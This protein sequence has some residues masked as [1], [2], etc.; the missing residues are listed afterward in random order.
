M[1][2]LSNMEYWHWL[3]FALVLIMFEMVVMPV[4]YF[5]WM[6]VAAGVVG[7]IMLAVPSLSFFL[8]IIIFTVISVVSLVV[9][10]RY[11]K[12]NPLVSDE[13]TLNRRGEQYIGRVFTLE[14]AIVNGAGK[15]KVDDSTWKENLPL[16]PLTKQNKLLPPLSVL[17]LLGIPALLFT[18]QVAV[19]V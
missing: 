9:H 18:D 13:P 6:G 10:K 15:V 8:Q 5:L 17:G 3:V 11:L 19:V 2:L 1:T 16:L 12:A 7:I 4:T 14:E